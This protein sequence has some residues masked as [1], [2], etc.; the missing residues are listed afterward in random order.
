MLRRAMSLAAAFSLAA[1]VSVPPRVP[2]AEQAPV[3]IE[4]IVI[5][6]TLSWSVTDVMVEVPATGGFAGCGNLMARSNCSTSFQETDYRAH[7]IVIRWR[8]HG[9]AQQTGEFVVKIPEGMPAGQVAWIEVIIFAPGQAGA[10]LVEAPRA[11]Q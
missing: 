5:R 3:V 7:P 4:G 8:E 6:N 11:S 10:K 1:C 2:E 9:Q